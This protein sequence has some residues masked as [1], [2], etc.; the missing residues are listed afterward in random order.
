MP[1]VIYCRIWDVIDGGSRWF[2]PGNIFPAVDSP[3][4][5]NWNAGPDRK[6]Y[7]A[8]VSMVGV[9]S[10]GGYSHVCGYICVVNARAFSIITK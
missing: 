9:V 6:P 2:L 7:A 4:L 8:K 5:G 3:V 10:Y 1:G